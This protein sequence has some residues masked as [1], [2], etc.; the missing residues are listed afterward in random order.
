MSE[1]AITKAREIIGA[2]IVKL[3]L[4][5]SDVYYMK[6]DISRFAGDGTPATGRI[7]FQI[8]FLTPQGDQRTIYSDVD[9]VLGS[10]IPPR[11]FYDGMNQRYAFTED[12]LKELL[13]GRDFELMENVKV[14]P[15]TTYFESPGHLAGRGGMMVTKYATI[16]TADEE[17][18]KIEKALPGESIGD[19]ISH[20]E[21]LDTDIAGIQ[22]EIVIA[23]KVLDQRVK[24]LPEAGDLAKRNALSKEKILAR[25]DE[26]SHLETLLGQVKDA[27]VE[28]KGR[29]YKLQTRE[30]KSKTPVYT[31][32][33]GKL[34]AMFPHIKGQID[35]L[36]ESVRS[37]TKVK[38][39]Q[40]ESP[41]E[42]PKEWEIRREAPMEPT[43]YPKYETK[44]KAS[45]QGK[46]KKQ[47]EIMDSMEGLVEALMEMDALLNE[48]GV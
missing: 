8:P 5:A 9:I 28:N 29:I 36:W 14:N 23:Q 21:A 34:V 17:E 20:L 35:S 25:K 11:Q 31:R 38:V 26:L 27:M 37:T 16:K 10:L 30:E 45:A 19:A 40:R 42:E 46:M 41:T 6:S 7:S 47:A 15:E 12:G 2:Q 48:A 44:E 43:E 3:N 13:H 22:K 18:K 24:G 4:P 1:Q 33:V 39:L 32:I